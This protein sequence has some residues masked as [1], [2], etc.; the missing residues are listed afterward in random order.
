VYTI[1]IGWGVAACSPQDWIIV[2]SLVE[3]PSVIHAQ[4]CVGKTT[5]FSVVVF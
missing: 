1:T 4:E 5:T 2:I 3:E